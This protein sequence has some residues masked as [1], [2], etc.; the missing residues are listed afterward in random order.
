MCFLPCQGGI[1][2]NADVN[3]QCVGSTLEDKAG[4]G[5]AQSS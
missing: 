4:P 3:L 5:P 2:G 1:S